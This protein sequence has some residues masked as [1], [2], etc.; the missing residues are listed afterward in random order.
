MILRKIRIIALCTAMAML[1]SGCG[2]TITE[3]IRQAA[4]GEVVKF[5]DMEY[6]RPDPQE[7]ERVLQE[8][9]DAALNGT[10]LEQVLEGIYAF[11]DIYD[12]FYTNYSI[13]EIHYYCDTSDSYWSEEYDFCVANISAADAGLEELYYAL[14]DSP[15]REDLEGE[16]YFG[17][18]YFDSYDGESIWDDT[19]LSLMEQEAQLQNRYYEITAQAAETEYYSEE[20]FSQYG[21]QLAELFVELVAL[22]QQIAA[23]AGYESY[24]EFAYDLYHYRDYTPAQAEGYLQAVGETMEPLY[25][26]VNQSDVWW[27]IYDYC[28]EGDTFDYV[29]TAS[30][31]MGGSVQEAFALLDEGELYH[32]STGKNKI[33]GAF[34]TYLWS[35]YEP[36]V[37]M[38]PVTDQSDKLTFAHEFGH[39][40]NDYVC[41]GSIAGTDVAEVHSQTMEYLSLLYNDDTEEL[42]AFKLADCLCTYVEQSA[43]ALFEQ[44]VY[45]LEGEELTIQNVQALY[46]QICSDFGFDSWGWDSR[47]YV[48]IEHFYTSPMYIVS[49]VV[50]NDVAFQIYQMEKEE[51]GAGLGVYEE[52][53]YSMDSYL[54]AFAE[55]YGLDSP[56]AEGRL[57]TVLDTLQTGLAEYL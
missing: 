43:Y 12:R 6:S 19:F 2:P 32:I 16:D 1:L 35:Y 4:A 57:E 55:Y 46:T 40:I 8:S 28:S 44:Q 25:C 38:C 42:E 41:Y 37:Y 56:F 54:L 27:T 10:D 17:E 45:M 24:P 26:R 53:V 31:N 39:F 34:E 50:S 18:G 51:T 23:Y 20:Y 22:R 3:L 52:C 15:Y 7:L 36:F 48:S 29:K 47:D 21:P 5:Q 11:Y 14:A 30:E 33:G 9:C 13:A 49:Y